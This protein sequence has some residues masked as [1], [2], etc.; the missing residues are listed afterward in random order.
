MTSRRARRAVEPARD[1]RGRPARP[2]R[3]S[4]PASCSAGVVDDVQ[5]AGAQG[6]PPVDPAQPVAGGERPDARRTRCRRRRRRD[7]CAPDQADRLRHLGPRV[8][9]RRR[10]AARSAPCSGRRPAPSGSPPR[11][12]SG[13]TRSSPSVAAP[14]AARADL[15]R[16]GHVR[17]ATSAPT[18]PRGRPQRDVRRAARRRGS[19]ARRRRGRRPRQPRRGALALVQRSV[20]DPASRRRARVAGPARR[21]ERRPARRT[22]RPAPPALGPAEQ[23]RQARPRA[24]PGRARPSAGVGRQAVT[25]AAP[26][27]E[28]SSAWPPRPARRR[29]PGRPDA[30]VIQS[31]GLT[32]IRCASTGRA[33]ALTS[34]GIT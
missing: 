9:R 10:A 31:S 15:E 20:V 7:R 30:W 3:A 29:R 16:S 18:A 32:V 23:R 34:S 12:W 2:R 26:A 28:A 19:R 11:R 13:A 17:A 21:P 6:H 22:A 4:T 8:E 27:L 33:T 25:A 1:A 14:P 5:L 24:R